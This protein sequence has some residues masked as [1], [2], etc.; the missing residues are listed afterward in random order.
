MDFYKSNVW[1]SMPIVYMFS[2]DEDFRMM[3]PIFPERKIPNFIK[4]M[5]NSDMINI[6]D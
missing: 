6:E 3:V 5:P 4:R 2:D 1:M